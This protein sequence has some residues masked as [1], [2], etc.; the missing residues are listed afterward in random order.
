M[1][2]AAGDALDEDAG[3]LVDEDRHGE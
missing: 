1:A 2:F 3:G